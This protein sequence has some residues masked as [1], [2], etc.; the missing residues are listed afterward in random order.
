M[1]N[2]IEDTPAVLGTAL[3]AKK[4]YDIVIDRWAHALDCY[5]QRVVMF[6]IR[7][8]VGYGRE[9]VDRMGYNQ[10]AKGVVDRNDASRWHRPPIGMGMTKLRETIASLE[11]KGVLKST[12]G[13]F[14]TSK[15]YTVNL[16]WNPDMPPLPV[17]KRLQEQK[18]SAL[19]DRDDG[20]DYDAVRR[21]PTS[22]YDTGC[23]AKR[24][25]REEYRE[26][27]GE[28]SVKPLSPLRADG[29]FSKEVFETPAEA[30][31]AVKNQSREN[32][33]Q[34]AKKD[35][36]LNSVDYERAFKAAFIECFESLPYRAWSPREKK[37]AKDL[38]ANLSG[39][40]VLDFIDWSV[41]HWNEVRVADLH[42]MS[43]PMDLYPTIGSLATG[44]IFAKYHMAYITARDKPKN[45][46]DR[47]EEDQI[48][49][50]MLHRGLSR[51][52]AI[53]HLAE[54][55]GAGKAEAEMEKV[56]ANIGVAFLARDLANE[57]AYKQ[58]AEERRALAERIKEEDARA[59]AA[60]PK[61]VDTV[62]GEVFLKPIDDDYVWK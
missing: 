14:T 61:G 37:N 7:H 54:Q 22:Q 11:A 9:V 23:V 3:F 12:E 20:A 55:R 31:T 47:T 40:D 2:K 25:H 41:R 5:E 44:F 1:Q 4:A 36:P 59:A 21:T 50:C 30:F 27:T 39:A 52:K 48:K 24:Q 62:G 32:L 33:K 51:E 35:K 8:S 29:G 57:A 49:L 38:A 6:L 16:Q 60:A 46:F 19:A 58:K 43:R 10:M 17:P 45:D 26:E 13:S 18:K 15:T 34:V 28:D 53:A 56:K 42:F